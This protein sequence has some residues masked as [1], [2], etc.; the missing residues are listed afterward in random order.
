M[1]FYLIRHGETDWNREGRFQGTEDIPLNETGISQSV[2]CAMAL[3]IARA[4]CIITSPLKRAKVTAEIIAEFTG[5]SPVIVEEGLTER[6]FGKIAG[7]LP[8]DRER[9]LQSGAETGIEPFEVLSARLMGVV[10]AYRTQGTYKNILLVSH[11]GA[12]NAILSVVSGGEIGT[13]KTVLKNVCI[14]K[15]HYDEDTAVIDFFNQSPQEFL[16]YPAG[17]KTV[18]GD[19]EEAPPVFW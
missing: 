15:I 11:G 19:Q 3:R 13:G 2:E 5:V 9:L 17:G 8:E 12:I 10:D 16:E 7:L 4:E 14:S 18:A 1:T 6:D